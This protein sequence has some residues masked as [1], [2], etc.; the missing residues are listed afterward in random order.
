MLQ[1]VIS[2]H[3]IGIIYRRDEHDAQESMY[4]RRKPAPDV[5]VSRT[6]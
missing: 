1:C 2:T 6:S 3:F 4:F 5:L